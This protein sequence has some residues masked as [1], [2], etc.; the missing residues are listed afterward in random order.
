MSALIVSNVDPFSRTRNLNVKY[1]IKVE[2]ER[3]VW[4]GLLKTTNV[5]KAAIVI[6]QLVSFAAFGL[7]FHTIS[8]I[9]NSSLTGGMGVEMSFNEST[10]AGTIKISM[11]PENIGWIPVEFRV[12]LA[13]INSDGHYI[14]TD[15]FEEH[16]E[17]GA[18]SSH[19]LTLELS[20]SE[21]Q[22]M[23]EEG[24][25]SDLEVILYLRTFY[26]LVGL[27]DLLKIEGSEIR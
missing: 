7:S 9:L 5:L 27:Y 3:P 26:N 14:A 24:T 13:A 8:G 17:P 10:G 1:L 12:E 15:Q 2:Q 4:R 23:M 11:S 16:M 25:V 19:T 20:P 6:L 22:K 18:K 21:V